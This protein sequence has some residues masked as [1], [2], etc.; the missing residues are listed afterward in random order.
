VNA[1]VI[2][3]SVAAK[4]FLPAVGETLVDEAVHLL[5]R[6]A[7]G[8]LQLLVPDLF[9]A[10]LANTFWKAIRQGRWQKAAAETAL[11]SLAARKLPTVSALSVLEIAFGIATAFDRT[12]YDALYVALA[13]HSRAQFITADEKLANAL[14]AQ[15]PVKWLGAV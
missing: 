5:R 4:W 9:W 15:L 12:V 13:V 3:A 1:A 11:A 14:A 7:K 10:E 8:E 6:Y 2:D